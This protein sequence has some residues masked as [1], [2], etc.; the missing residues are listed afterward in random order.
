MRSG[1]RTGEKPA[2]SKKKTALVAQHLEKISREA[3]KRYQDVVRQYVRGRH[4]IYALYRKDKLYYVGLASNL[5]NRLRHH[6]IDRHGH[7]WDRFSIY[8]TIGDSHMKEL[9]SLFLR[10]FKPAG[11]KQAGKFMVSEDLRKRFTGDVREHH[12][13]E[14]VLLIGK[15]KGR[16]KDKS[17]GTISDGKQPVLA[18]YGNRPTLL[19]A[20]YKRKIVKAHV[21]QDGS[22][23]LNGKVYLS[24]SLA[25]AAAKNR[26]TCNGWRF[27][28]YER[29]P[30]DWVKLDTLRR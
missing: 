13:K 17:P 10:M 2:M 6:L 21:R 1:R 4:G 30:G 26:P 3:L 24:P 20:M 7:S 15:K 16:G 18:G 14:L 9:E 28:T 8:L 5:R 27:W 23:R 29:A 11:N 12:R 22:I 25:G 19:K